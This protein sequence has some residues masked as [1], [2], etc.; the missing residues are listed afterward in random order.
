M[1]MKSIEFQCCRPPPFSPFYETR[2]DFKLLE[3][4]PGCSNDI[5]LG[6]AA[7][8]PPPWTDL[9]EAAWGSTSA[10]SEFFEAVERYL[11]LHL[12]SERYSP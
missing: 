12:D 6:T 4:L 1:L 2:P 8:V 3:T 11:H 9:E 5:I 10:T 7:E